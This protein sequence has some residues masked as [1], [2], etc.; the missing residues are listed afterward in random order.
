MS[1]QTLIALTDKKSQW[2]GF[3]LLQAASSSQNAFNIT[4][5][6]FRIFTI[7]FSPLSSLTPLSCTSICVACAHVQGTRWTAYHFLLSCLWPHCL[8]LLPFPPLLFLVI[9]SFLLNCSF[10]SLPR[11]LLCLFRLFLPPL[12]RITCIPVLMMVNMCHSLSL[13]SRC[14]QYSFH[15]RCDILVFRALSWWIEV[16]DRSVEKPLMIE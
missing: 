1:W 14:S 15:E 2:S 10:F 11:A 8:A 6:A 16:C 3:Y 13:P 12:Y 9:D 7:F 4:M 5:L